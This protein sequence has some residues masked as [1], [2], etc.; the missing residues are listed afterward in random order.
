[1]QSRRVRLPSV[2]L[3]AW[4][5]VV[6]IEGL[7][8]AEPG[9]RAVDATVRAIAVGPE[10]GFTADELAACA[11]H[12]ALSDQVLRVETAAIAAAVLLMREM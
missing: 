6:T 10:G 5:D 7:A 3:R 4:A 11:R 12:V 2:S 8:L 9:G 1:M